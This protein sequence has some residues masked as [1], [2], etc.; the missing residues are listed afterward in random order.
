[1]KMPPS[2]LPPGSS[3]EDD[4]VCADIYT[5][6]QEYPMWSINALRKHV[7]EQIKEATAEIC[8]ERDENMEALKKVSVEM[9][10]RISDLVDL[11]MNLSKERDA[12]KISLMKA[13]GVTGQD[14]KDTQFPS[15]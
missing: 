3:F 8:E 13:L 11:T 14:I 12:L 2:G 15:P 1:M 6:W 4:A 9:T 5:Y 7:A 10:Q